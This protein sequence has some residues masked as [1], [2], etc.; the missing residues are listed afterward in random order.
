MNVAQREDQELDLVPG[1]VVGLIGAPGFG[2]TRIGLRMLAGAGG[3]LACVDVR[4]WL[5]PAAAWEAG[6][7]AERLVVVRCSDPLQW[8]QVTA[9]LVEGMGA[10]YAEVPA[11]VA[12]QMLRRLGALA[13]ARSTS[14]I[15]RPVEGELPGGITFTRLEAQGVA[16]YGAEEGNGRL[17][18]RRVQLL[19]SGKGTGGIQQLI[20]VEDDGTDAV[21]VVS[22]VAVAMP[23][24]AVG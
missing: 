10:V 17:R 14:L 22:R 1:Q 11:G 18:S 8:P 16:W 21:R 15:L 4:G 13:R 20:E 24:R 23:E 19:A 7:S 2:L 6:V 9:A 12:P 3:W 5:C